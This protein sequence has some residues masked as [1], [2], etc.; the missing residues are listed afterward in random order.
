ME[1]NQD[2]SRGGDEGIEDS[3]DVDDGDCSDAGVR[4]TDGDDGASR[5]DNITT[6]WMRKVVDAVGGYSERI[7]EGLRDA[8]RGWSR[9]IHRVHD[10]LR[11]GA[12]AWNERFQRPFTRQYSSVEAVVNFLDVLFIFSFLLWK[13]KEHRRAMFGIV[14]LVN[15]GVFLPFVEAVGTSAK[16]ERSEKEEKNSREVRTAAEERLVRQTYEEMAA[17]GGDDGVGVEGGAVM[18]EE[19]NEKVMVEEDNEIAVG[20]SS[21]DDANGQSYPFLRSGSSVA[22]EGFRVEDDVCAAKLRKRRGVRS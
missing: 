22:D 17:G 15:A 2:G 18:G 8:S 9:R 14:L 16:A 21:S 11:T 13:D 6:S 3:D 7:H 10:A 4:V 20:S 19:V 5:S 1:K 12:R